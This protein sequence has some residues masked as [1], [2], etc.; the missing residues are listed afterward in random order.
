MRKGKAMRSAKIVPL[1]L[2]WIL[3]LGCPSKAAMTWQEQYDLGI[4]Y[5]S[6]GNYKE[7][8]IAFEAAIAIEPG[9][10]DSYMRAAEAYLSSGGNTDAA[11]ALVRGYIATGNEDLLWELIFTVNPP[12]I[13][14]DGYW[15][16]RIDGVTAT[17]YE[18]G[19]DPDSQALREKY[20]S[21]AST[22]TGC[23]THFEEPLSIEICGEHLT[24]EQANASFYSDSYKNY[25][26]RTAV[27]SGYISFNTELYRHSQI[28]KADIVKVDDGKRL[29][30][31]SNDDGEKDGTYMPGGVWGLTV[32]NMEL[33]S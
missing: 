4:R 1:A 16:Y 25:N 12:N 2:L 30:V 33:L 22:T 21:L 26:G 32:E 31:R 23:L 8:I 28:F 7:A 14:N 9:N 11:N 17:I 5:L 20:G 13:V 3:L 19:Q 29:L 15:S 27:I 6:E 10:T 24:I 18:C